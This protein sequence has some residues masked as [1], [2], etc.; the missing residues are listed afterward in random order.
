M[1]RVKYKVVNRD[2]HQLFT[3]VTVVTA[4][5]KFSAC[6]IVRQ[7]NYKFDSSR[8]LKQRAEILNCEPV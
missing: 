7:K 4:N 5:S 8:K 6:V 2:G 3:D 1:Y